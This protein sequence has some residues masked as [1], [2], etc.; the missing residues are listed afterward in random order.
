MPWFLVYETRRKVIDA[1]S[2]MPGVELVQVAD[3]FRS[4]L[5]DP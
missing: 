3:G 4:F 5:S 1:G 2:R